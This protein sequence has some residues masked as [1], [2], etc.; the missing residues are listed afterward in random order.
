MLNRN[1][2]NGIVFVEKAEKMF[3]FIKEEKQFS[4]HLAHCNLASESDSNFGNV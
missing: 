3:K 1:Q 4:L 2:P